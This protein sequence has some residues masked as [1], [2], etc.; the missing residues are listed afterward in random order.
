M[1]DTN[2]MLYIGLDKQEALIHTPGPRLVLVGGSSLPFSINS[3][4]IADSLNLNPIN[5]GI[6]AGI[7]LKF[8][9]NYSKKFIRSGDIVILIPEYHHYYGVFANGSM[10]LVKTI[11]EVQPQQADN[12]KAFQ[13]IQVL[14]YLPKYSAAKLKKVYHMN[15]G[16]GEI[17]PYDRRSFNKY[18]DAIVHWKLPGKP[19]SP[20]GSLP[21]ALN[22]SI[23]ADIRKYQAELES[24]G[25]KVFVS[26]PNY[27]E[28]SYNNAQSQI[29][30][31]FEQLKS[32]NI[33]LMGSP[34]RYKIPD[35]LLFDTPYHL[36]KT[37]VDLRTNLLIGDVL[38]YDPSLRK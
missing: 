9:L 8:M 10:E 37:G 6:H 27:Q 35:S 34:E 31:V 5:T 25:A 38:D 15:D 11:F 2:D 28:D 24:G 23:I 26:F 1:I 33:R 17:T 36:T 29:E 16:D 7:G 30:D 22:K 32:N 3:E 20:W 19:V 21:G 14:K 13:W 18:G 4:L 12:I